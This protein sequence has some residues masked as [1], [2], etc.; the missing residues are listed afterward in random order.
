MKS[1][2]I[3]IYFIASG[4]IAFGQPV[5]FIL[6]GTL[7]ENR[8]QLYRNLV[9]NIILKN[10]SHPLSDSTEDQWQDAFQAIE[11]IC[12]RSPLTDNKIYDAFSNIQQRSIAFQHDLLEVAY[13]NYPG[14]FLKQVM[15]IL[16]NT[17]DSKIFALCA[18]YILKVDSNHSQQAFLWKK[19]TE[20]FRVATKDP[21]IQELKYQLSGN[22]SPEIKKLTG[23]LLNKDFLPGNVIMLSFQRK[24]R[25]YPGI[26]I[27][28]DS[29][30]NFLHDINGNLFSV[31]QLARSMTDLPG[32]LENGNTPEGIFRMDGFDT[33]K[34][35][36]IGPTT[37]IQLTMPFEYKASHFFNDT[38]L[39][40][41]L[42]DISLY[43]NLLPAELKSYHPLYQSYFAGMAGRTAIIAH[44]TTID[45]AYYRNQAYYP[46]TPTQ[47]CLTTKEI[48]N[49]DTG[50]LVESDQQKLANALIKAGG[51]HG[52]AVVIN[53]DD[54]QKPVSLSEISDL[55]IEAH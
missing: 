7:K 50:M 54:Q 31:P 47:G 18:V 2:L 40:D 30:G 52:Y 5:P 8:Q 21:V 48:W 11:L 34:S 35:I 33:S 39:S 1:N 13:A 44:G 22:Q 46:L 36:F 41:T 3:L 12:Y 49:E 32:Y 23:S 29:S 16:E 9:N 17:N 45:P 20:K 19:T 26:V 51:P 24:N 10:L 28:K 14:V 15:S 37:N 25:N 6:K 27:I 38:T 4:C 55:I 42:W 43:R 53:L